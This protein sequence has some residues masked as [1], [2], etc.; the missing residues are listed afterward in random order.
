MDWNKAKT[1]LI[2][3]FIVIDVFLF[4][5]VIKTEN[6]KIEVLEFSEEII[7]A[8]EEKNI[9]IGVDIPVEYRTLP[10]LEVEY[11]TFDSQSDLISNLLGSFETIN[12]NEYFIN[13]KGESIRIINGKKIVFFLRENEGECNLNEESY[14]NIISQFVNEQEIDLSGYILAEIII[15]LEGCKIVYK[16]TFEGYILEN[17]YYIFMADNNGITGFEYQGIKNI[18]ISRANIQITKADEALLRLLEDESLYGDTIT[19]V[20]ICY[21][22]DEKQN[23]WENVVVDNL[24]PTYKIKFESGRVKYLIEKE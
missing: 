3:A 15:N 23:D 10:L 11:E 5:H 16:E 21:Y 20:E 7:R 8:L 4:A 17:S 14:K 1:I 22:R 12:E 18:K 19:S 24:D 9:K 13:E 6:R 2:L